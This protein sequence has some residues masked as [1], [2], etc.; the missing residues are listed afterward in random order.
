MAASPQVVIAY[1]EMPWGPGP[2]PYETDSLVAFA[3]DGTLIE[4]L[5]GFRPG[6]SWRGPTLGGLVAALENAVAAKP[7]TF[8]PL[9]AEFHAAKIPFQHAVIQG[10]K[11]LFDPSNEKKPE[12]SWRVAWPKL[13]AFFSETVSQDSFWTKVEENERADLIP[14]REWLSVLAKKFTPAWPS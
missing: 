14:T 6:N 13:L 11:K 4:R 7:N 2:A 9:L 5:N 3:E 12:F 8:L 10:F 1:H